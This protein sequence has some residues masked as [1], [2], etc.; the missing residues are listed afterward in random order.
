MRSI[1]LVG[2]FTFESYSVFTPA[3]ITSFAGEN[4]SFWFIRSTGLFQFGENFV[5]LTL[6]ADVHTGGQDASVLFRVIN[7]LC[8]MLEA[9]RLRF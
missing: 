3:V 9:S 1:L 8:K 4:P 5:F 2:K 6:W 7:Y